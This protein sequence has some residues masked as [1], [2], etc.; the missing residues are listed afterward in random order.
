MKQLRITLL[1]SFIIVTC[2]TGFNYA[3]VPGTID[4]SFATN[5]ILILQPNT[6]GTDVANGMEVLPNDN[7]LL[8]GS[9][10]TGFLLSDAA[11]YRILPNGEVDP[12][13]G[14]NGVSI[15]DCGGTQDY[16][17]TMKVLPNGKMI[18]AG[19]VY[20]GGADVNFFAARLTENGSLDATFGTNG[21]AIIPNPA[22]V[23][24]DVANAI[25][26]Q[27]DGKIILAGEWK[28]PGFTDG[29]TA[30]V[31]LNENGS[32]DNSFGTNG[33]VNVTNS[34]FA[35]D[36][37]NDVL[38]LSDGSIITTGYADVLDQ[39]VI[40]EKFNNSGALD[41]TFGNN[42][43]AIYN[44]TTGYD[45]G[46]AIKQ[47]PDGKI[48]IAGKIGNGGPAF[49]D[50]LL[51]AITSNGALD[52]NFGIGG[53]ASK[54]IKVSEAALDLLVEPSGKIVLAGASGVGGLGGD[55]YAVCRFTENGTV[56]SSFGTNGATIS[57]IASFFS[58]AAVIGMQSNGKL[59]VGGRGATIKNDY[60]LVRYFSDPITATCA[61]PVNPVT[62][63]ITSTSATLSW[64]NP[65]NATAFQVRYR[66]N[67]DDNWTKVFSNNTSITLTGLTP[68]VK[69]GW[70][71][72]AKC[73]D[74]N[75]SSFSNGSKFKTSPLRATDGAMDESSAMQLYPNPS[76]GTFQLSFNTVES[77]TATATIQIVNIFGQVVDSRI[78]NIVD[79]TLDET[80]NFS[81]QLAPGSYFIRLSAGNEL[82][83]SRFILQ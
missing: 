52:P 78:L 3:Q 45:V 30:L 61:A 64:D 44:L 2:L 77:T 17:Q 9:T 21:I 26:I 60:A 63:A 73:D 62:F 11:V 29:H 56:D 47:H 67:I 12:T 74:G 4:T 32:I 59:V 5:G 69:Y 53:V 33:I 28:V 68:A 18:I 54:N 35:N 49:S 81:G 55:D 72:R 66:S 22:G 58:E 16:V 34:G 23:G 1:T 65:G 15:F 36:L 82:Y 57:V 40:I 13:F 39:R 50:F 14:V 48:L 46:W 38:L 25:A 75:V 10:E 31:R 19:G 7:V 71:V 8:A 70:S 80:F 42:G 41:P 79:G 83:S 20:D 6:I 24:E 76:T 43:I 27:P 51:M 37:A